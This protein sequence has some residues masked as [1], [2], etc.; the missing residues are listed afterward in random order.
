MAMHSALKELTVICRDNQVA[1]IQNT[2]GLQVAV[3]ATEVFIHIGYI[4]II[5]LTRLTEC[6][7]GDSIG[8]RMEGLGG[9]PPIIVEHPDEAAV[10]KIGFMGWKQMKVTDKR[11]LQTDNFL[12]NT[13]KNLFKHKIDFVS[14]EIGDAMW[15][16]FPE[17]F[18]F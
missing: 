10:L 1:V 17:F 8:Q 6:L 3:E 7:L 14:T 12:T 15:V 11:C 13:I 16:I 2:G 9:G 18:Q 5:L 4:L